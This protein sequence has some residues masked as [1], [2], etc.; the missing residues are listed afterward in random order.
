FTKTGA[1]T[2]VL[3]GNSGGFMGDTTVSAGTLAV[4]GKFGHGGTL[5]TVASGATL[6]GSGRIGGN[7]AL[8]S[9]ATLA[10]GNSIGTLTVS[11]DFSFA[12]GSTYLV[13][14]DPSGTSSDLLH[15][16]GTADLAG[17]VKHVGLDGVYAE[18]SSYTI[19]T[20][21][22]GYGSTRFDGVAS[23][24]AFLDSSLDYSGNNVD[25]VLKRNDVAL[26]DVAKTPNQAA[27]AQAVANLPKTNPIYLQILPMNAG[28]A[29]ASYE[30]LSGELTASTTSGLIAGAQ[31]SGQF[32]LNRINHAFDAPIASSTGLPQGDGETRDTFT[33]YASWASGYGSIGTS[34]AT[35]TTAAVDRSSAGFM[36]GID[37]ALGEGR[38]GL[39]AGFQRA[40]FSADTL[41][42]STDTDSY[43]AGIYGGTRFGDFRLTGGAA[44]SFNQLDTTRS[45]VVGGISDTLAGSTDASTY[46]AFGELGYDIQAGRVTFTPFAGLSVVSMTTDGYTET[47]GVTALTVAKS[48]TTVGYST[49]GSRISSAFALGE[50]DMRVSG[51]LGWR[52]AFGDTAP[53]STNA[54]SGSSFI[55]SGTP[56]AENLAVVGA[57][58]EID[59]TPTATLGLTYE[60][61]FGDGVMD[62]SGAARLTV[63]F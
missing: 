60:G 43:T 37:T 52:H 17:T 48:T 57:G 32:V 18:T 45:V 16:L 7:A 9:G 55:V 19:L 29:Q 5:L 40:R 49:L 25:L 35:A 56:L 22:G 20:A 34:D 23:D 24:Y 31:G 58:F 10:T 14:T 39:F 36:G 38:I 53:T 8:Q 61:E 33:G 41:A 62:N 2:L 21:D 13:E 11:G 47:G 30:A 26:P 63:R 4:N 42:S 44:Y 27:T 1:G 54:I 28:Q 15:V 3:S 12:D 51:M 46:Q 59:L 6:A 50:T